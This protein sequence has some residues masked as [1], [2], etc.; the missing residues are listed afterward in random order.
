MAIGDLCL[1]LDIRGNH[2]RSLKWQLNIL[3]FLSAWGGSLEIFKMVIEDSYL[4]SPHWQRSLENIKI[5]TGD[6]S[7]LPHIGK[8]HMEIIGEYQN[9]DWRFLY[10]S[11]I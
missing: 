10:F 7:L 5:A 1:S 11:L 3:V 4:P 9:G 2:W 8:D 6:F